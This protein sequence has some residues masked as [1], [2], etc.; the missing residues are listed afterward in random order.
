[1]NSLK[2]FIDIILLRARPQDVSFSYRL[3]AITAITS[4]VS[5]I[6]VL[7]PASPELAQYLGKQNS[8]IMISVAEHAFFAAT[9]W[10]ILKL[11]GFTGR[12][13]QA[14]TAMF[15]VSTIIRLLVW[16]V[17]GLL[18]TNPETSGTGVAGFL[19]IGLSLW[20]WV[21]YAHIFRE[22]LESRFGVGLLYTIVSQII[23]SML[24]LT[25]INVNF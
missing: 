18:A 6:L 21:V 14:M 12:F 3:L 19:I 22:T 2:I 9:V 5:Y 4:I 1:M 7:E 11:R 23:T 16:L 17:M 13:V 10:V 20:I 15:G 8:I 24:L 25:V